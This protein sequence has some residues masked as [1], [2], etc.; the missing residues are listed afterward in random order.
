MAE[1]QGEVFCVGLAI[2]DTI[3]RVDAIPTQ[4]VKLYAKHRR[5]IGGG[6]AAT[7]SVAIARLGGRVAFAGRSGDDA[8][9][10]ALRAELAGEGVDTSWYRSFP[11]FHS[12]SSVILVDDAGDR[13]IVAYADPA[14]PTTADW[15]APPHLGDALLC[16]LSWPQGALRCLERARQD[17]I[18][19]VLDADIS[20]HGRDAVAPLIEAADH[21]VFSRPGLAQFAGTEEI[22]AGLKAA[23][24]PTHVLVGVTDGEA[25]FYWL[26][27]DGTL[28]NRRPPAVKVVDTVGAGDAF[29]GALALALARRW[30]LE[31]AI[32]FANAVAA[33][34]CTV[35]GGRAGLP[36]ANDLYRFDHSFA[37]T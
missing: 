13:L 4:P 5:T 8:V 11:G 34:K 33:L 28:C 32:D 19:A 15:L 14:L 21:V 7:A 6:P 20:R 24:R 17:G 36:S 18:P 30:P 27:R 23:A 10:V 26:R 29:H 12:P 37:Q 22:G 16:D 31:R 35:P 9:G 3:L 2:E 25:G 1:A